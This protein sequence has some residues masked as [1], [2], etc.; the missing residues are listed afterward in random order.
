MNKKMLF[1]AAVAVM[2]VVAVTA[3]MTL[4]GNDGGEEELPPKDM[5]ENII[6]FNNKTGEDLIPATEEHGNVAEA[7]EGDIAL[8]SEEELG[9]YQLIFM[10][11]D[12]LDDETWAG[13]VVDVSLKDITV[14]TYNTL[15][16]YI[17]ADAA[18][19]TAVHL[20]PGDAVVVS[21]YENEDGERVAYELE[22]VRVE[23]EPLTKDEIEKMYKEAN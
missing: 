7:D 1:A 11:S 10:K 16:T 19:N 4:R 17:L 18:K 20:K 23:D 14:N 12:I 13:W 21:F 2:I 5:P 8:P 9:E 3:G 22:R 15:T 6:D